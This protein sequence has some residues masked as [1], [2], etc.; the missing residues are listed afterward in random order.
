MGACAP[1]QHDW[2]E[3]PCPY[4]QPGDHLWVRETWRIGAWDEG[5]SAI[6]IDYLADNYWRDEWL[7]VPDIAPPQ[8]PGAI[9]KRQSSFQKYMN[10]SLDDA[11]KSGLKFDASGA[12]HWDHGDSPCRTR[13]TIHMP[14]WA[15][16]IT[17]E[18]VNVRVE[19][20]QDISE[21]DAEAEGWTG[22]ILGRYTAYH[23]YWELWESING[24]GSWDA[25]P[26][27]WVIEFRRAA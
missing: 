1:F 15:S 22:P 11:E 19:R 14:R 20:L 16:R 7:F 8:K 3:S 24:K 6:A 2:G 23:W 5:I 25:N 26:W 4:G 21:A 27:V 18:V 17:L 12:Y 9:F 10:Q 13:P